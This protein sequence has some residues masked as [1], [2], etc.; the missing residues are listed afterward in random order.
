ML[1]AVNNFTET[2]YGLVA[3]PTQDSRNNGFLLSSHCCTFG[4]YT[5]VVCNAKES[6]GI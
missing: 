1:T 3:H 2:H 4:L 6:R 5:D